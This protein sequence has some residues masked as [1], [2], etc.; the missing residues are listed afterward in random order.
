MNTA[1]II[2]SIVIAIFGFAGGGG[3]SSGGGG[4]GGGSSY[5]GG[6]SYHSSS[7]SSSSSSSDGD[8]VLALITFGVVFLIICALASKGS[9]FSFK[10]YNSSDEEKDI[11][12]K[13]KQIFESYQADWTN[14]N[15]EN[16][17]T[18]TTS[19]YYKHV[20]YMLELLKN[21]H[22]VNKVSQLKVHKVYLL[23]PVKS[24]TNL[25]LKV[26]V[27]YDFSGLDEVIDAKDNKNLYHAKASHATETWNFIYDGKTLKLDGISQPTESSS[28]LVRSLADFASGNKL[29][30]SPDWGRYALPSRGLIFGGSSMSISDINNH[31]I[32]KWGD[33][34]VQLYTYAETPGQYASSYYIVGQINVPK[35]Y[36]G[37]IVKSR[38]FKSGKK[39]DKSYEKFELEWNKFNDRY[40]VYAASRDALPAFEL[41]NPKFMEFLYGKNP[42]YSLEVVDN[43]IYIYA[44]I[45]NIT[46]QDYIDMLAVLRAAYDE[47]KM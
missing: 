17:K 35:D 27:A 16:I 42:S 31:V 39:P 45:K 46:E 18:Y 5:S 19:D 30:Y 6:S 12:E 23:T 41:L 11:H 15:L 47:L 20:S 8:W 22:R 25:P 32:G 37:V 13:A 36:L 28:H 33:L 4:G 7:S 44:N 2:T 1:A 26:R 14:F 24:D 10:D 40:E 43:V 3:S 21:L 34:L 9:K 29:F 38:E